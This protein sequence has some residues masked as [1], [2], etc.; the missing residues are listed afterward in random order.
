M[1][2]LPL[3]H[4]LLLAEFDIDRGATLRHAVPALPPG[5]DEAAAVPR[6]LPE[7]AHAHAHTW[8][9]WFLPPPPP[10]PSSSSSPPPSSPPRRC[11]S[12]VRVRLVEGRRRGA[13]VKALAV[14][15]SCPWVDS[16]R[17]LL[18][19]A[20]DEYFDAPHVGTLE[21]AVRR[22]NS[23]WD[24]GWGEAHGCAPPTTRA[25]LRGWPAVAGLSVG[26]AGGRRDAAS[27]AAGACWWTAALPWS[28]RLSAVVRVSRGLEPL[29][30]A[31]A[32]LCALVRRLGDGVM[33]AVTAVLM[34]Q[35]V[36]VLGARG[37]PAGDVAAGVLA[38]AHAVCPPLPAS[39]IAPRL[40]PS[41]PLDDLAFL[42]VPGYVAGVVNPLWEG[43]GGAWWDVLVVLG[44]APASPGDDA[45]GLLPTAVPGSLARLQYDDAGGGTGEG[46][47]GREAGNAGAVTSPTASA[48]SFSASTSSLGAGGLVVAGGGTGVGGG[49]GGG[50][51]GG[52]AAR[53]RAATISSAGSD[54]SWGVGVGGWRLCDA[55]PRCC[56][57]RKRSASSTA[58][59]PAAST[60]AADSDASR[61]RGSSM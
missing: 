39:A 40:F 36:A 55:P 49:G 2:P 15:S 14:V 47:A 54:A 43:K 18:L 1:D 61:W 59:P 10:P 5:V 8:T 51:T 12:V 50:G 23:G 46:G 29:G 11:V 56:A 34:G 41:A 9:A 42:S 6:M 16:L 3:A 24:A 17:P 53:P 35:R 45:A 13:D 31:S 19:A 58:R 27:D 38:L 48:S 30:F 21:A 44:S 25:L 57:A 7:G 20:L 52:A 4:A 22:L 26:R 37:V 28:P 32:S 60:S 33:P